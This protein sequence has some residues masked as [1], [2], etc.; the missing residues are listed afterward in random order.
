MKDDKGKNPDEQVPQ[1][2]PPVPLQPGDEEEITLPPIIDVIDKEAPKLRWYLDPE[3][4]GDETLVKVGNKLVEGGFISLMVLTAPISGPGAIGGAGIR[5]GIRH[6]IR[7][8][9]KVLVH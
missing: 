7:K 4:I 3:F 9:G 2:N 6:G 8:G 5:S 1:P